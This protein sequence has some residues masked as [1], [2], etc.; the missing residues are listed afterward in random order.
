MQ[1]RFGTLDNNLV[2]GSILLIATWSTAILLR[3]IYLLADDTS[4][5][6]ILPAWLRARLPSGTVFPSSFLLPGHLCLVLYGGRVVRALSVCYLVMCLLLVVR[7]DVAVSGGG[8]WQLEEVGRGYWAVVRMCVAG[9]LALLV[10]IM[11][12]HRALRMLTCLLLPVAAAFD[13][14]S[15]V[16]VVMQLNCPTSVQVSV[17]GSGGSAYTS[18][19][20]CVSGLLPSS[21]MLWFCAWRDVVSAVL[22]LL[23]LSLSYWLTGL[24][25]W[26]SD[27]VVIPAFEHQ[28]WASQVHAKQRQRQR[29]TKAKKKRDPLLTRIFA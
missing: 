15:E 4:F 2:L 28:L 12:T 27:S 9:V 7:V 14:L 24:Y 6:N 13:L 21:S 11:H 26:F 10:S 22:A 5:L 3:L 23:L 29:H 25:G 8:V 18:A 1:L 16:S 20:S 17:A 19:V